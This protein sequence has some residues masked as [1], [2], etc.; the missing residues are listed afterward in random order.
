ELEPEIEVEQSGVAVDQPSNIADDLREVE[1]YEGD[2]FLFDQRPHPLDDLAGTT[3]VLDNVFENLLHFLQIRGIGGKEALGRLRVTENARERLIQ[4]IS[5]RRGSLAHGGD[6]RDV[7]E[8]LA[9][10]LEF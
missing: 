9:V 7:R 5:Q 4:L 8:L 3:V 2:Y 1:G 6:A 10:V